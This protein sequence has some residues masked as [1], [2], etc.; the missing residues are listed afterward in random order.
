MKKTLVIASLHGNINLVED[1]LFLWEPMVDEIVFL[2]N[3]FN[4]SEPATLVDTAHWLK[5]SLTK[6]KRIHLMGFEERPFFFKDPYFRSNINGKLLKEVNSIVEPL[7][8][9]NLQLC[10]IAQDKWICSHAGILNQWL[11]AHNSTIFETVNLLNH[12]FKKHIKENSYF[13][14]FADSINEGGTSDKPGPLTADWVN[15]LEPIPHFNQIVGHS[16]I[17]G[18]QIKF[19]SEYTKTSHFLQPF[20]SNIPLRD[21]ILSMNIS[22]PFNLN[23]FILIENSKIY[24]ATFFNDPAVQLNPLIYE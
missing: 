9:L 3:Y 23:S 1:L 13:A 21:K 2:G 5:Y 22:I 11:P 19:L 7:F 15:D 24:P 4:L 20:S 10:H 6:S 14:L 18:L 16:N 17:P 8:A 12:R